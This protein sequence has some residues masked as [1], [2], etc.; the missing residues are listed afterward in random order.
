MNS[1]VPLANQPSRYIDNKP[2][3]TWR[4]MRL[5]KSTNNEALI[6]IEPINSTSVLLLINSLLGV[7]FYKLAFY[8]GCFYH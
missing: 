6:F 8:S 7:L 3:V 2:I 1:F 4:K 5:L